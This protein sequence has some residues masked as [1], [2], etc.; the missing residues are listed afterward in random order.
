[1]VRSTSRIPWL[2]AGLLFA[3]CDPH[4]ASGPPAQDASRADGGSGGAMGDTGAAAEGDGSV[5]DAGRDPRPDAGGEV[6]GGSTGPRPDG[7][8]DG[9]A[10]AGRDANVDLDSGATVGDAGNVG[11]DASADAG[12]T[13]DAGP[14]PIAD[15]ATYAGPGPRHPVGVWG[16]ALPCGRIGDLSAT[17][18]PILDVGHATSL[19]SLH[20]GKDRLLSIGSDDHWVLWDTTDL[21]FLAGGKGVSTAP[22]PQQSVLAGDTFLVAP[23]LSALQVRSAVTGRVLTTVATPLSARVN[24]PFGL[25]ADGSYVWAAN[26]AGITVW[27][28]AG[29]VVARATGDYSSAKVFAAKGE[30]RVAAGASGSNVIQNISTSTGAST[31][32]AGFSGTFHSWFRD[33][34]HFFSNVASTVRIYSKAGVSQAI[35]A[36]PTLDRLTG[37]GTVFWTHRTSTPGYPLDIYTLANPSTPTKSYA[38]KVLSAVYQAADVLGVVHYGEPVLDIVKLTEA[39][40]PMTSVALPVSYPEVFAADA[41]GSWWFSHNA[42]AL[43]SGT[44]LQ[45]PL[46]CGDAYSIAGSDTGIAAV[47][48]AGGGLHVFDLEPGAHRYLGSIPFNSSHVEISTDGSILA[49]AA[50]LRD[51]QYKSDRSLRVYALPPATVTKVW[52]YSWTSYPTLFFDFSMSATGNRFGHVTGTFDSNRWRYTRQVLDVA[53][54]T[55]WFTQTATDDTPLR[56]S[57]DGTRVAAAT[58]PKNEAATA[59]NIYENGVLIGAVPGSPVAWTSA[60]RLLVNRYDDRGASIG[61]AL[62]DE[63]GV[64]QTTPTLPN[65]GAV[66]VISADLLYSQTHNAIFS[67]STGAKTWAGSTGAVVGSVAGQQVVFTKHAEPHYVLA[68]QR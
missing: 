42:G 29:L 40:M 23:S 57:P 10:E 13:V 31:N 32:S 33:G 24:A 34:D 17:S 39:G 11:L 12:G 59:T 22:V 48:T 37:Q 49:A 43:F 1:M 44:D 36:L 41:S 55:P 58:G 5:F 63:Q 61:A 54:A 14:P 38:L 19:A 62:Y 25:A 45:H 28:T 65:F 66:R 30:L 67:L 26:S 53:N 9:G 52:P 64:P 3:A 60:D 47:A 6:D 21:S 18:G 20:P 51:A 4:V 16:T 2:L 7:G 15:D 27:N 68:E 56:L 50:S 35:V 8:I 46:S